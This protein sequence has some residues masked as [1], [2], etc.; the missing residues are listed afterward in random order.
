M[1]RFYGARLAIFALAGMTLASLAATTTSV[2]NP[3]VRD[4]DLRSP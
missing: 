1:L 4:R 2:T 3:R